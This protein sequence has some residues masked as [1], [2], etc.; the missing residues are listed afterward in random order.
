MVPQV[1]NFSPQNISLSLHHIVKAPQKLNALREVYSYWPY[2]A[3]NLSTIR[4]NGSMN[5]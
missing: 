4:T 3:L 1:L 5:M 2:A